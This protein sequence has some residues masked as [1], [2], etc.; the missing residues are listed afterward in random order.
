MAVDG[1][2]EYQ[3][4]CTEPCQVGCRFWVVT[5][6]GEYRQAPDYS[7]P[8]PVEDYSAARRWTSGHAAELDLD[9]AR[10]GLIGDSAGR[11]GS[12]HVSPGS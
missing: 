9:H 7:D 5:F 4:I 3:D 8:T 6:G 11:A 2:G 1:C 12:R 10:L